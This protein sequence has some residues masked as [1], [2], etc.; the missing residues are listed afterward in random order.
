MAKAWR[1]PD[2]YKG[3]YRLEFADPSFKGLKVICKRHTW[4]SIEVAA[5][6]LA[7]DVEAI[8]EGT[9]STEDLASL[10]LGL[11]EFANVIVSW[12]LEIPTKDGK[13]LY[14]PNPTYRTLKKLDLVF[15]MQLFLVWLRIIVRIERNDVEP[16]DIPMSTVEND[17]G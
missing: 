2:A 4:N 17:N 1:L 10:E 6:L 3:T 7:I 14:T 12:N 16:T 15:V 9:I 5:K 11:V 8:R 13:G